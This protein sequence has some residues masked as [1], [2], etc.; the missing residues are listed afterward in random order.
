MI[1]IAKGVDSLGGRL[2]AV[3]STAT[4]AIKTARGSIRPAGLALNDLVNGLWRFGI[5][6]GGFSI[7][8]GA[9]AGSRSLSTHDSSDS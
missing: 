3:M 7:G 4:N 9:S 5:F 2:S 1:F 6:F 8:V